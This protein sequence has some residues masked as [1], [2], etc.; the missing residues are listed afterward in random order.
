MESD[1]PAT[2]RI[3][4]PALELARSIGDPDEGSE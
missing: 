4:L 3:R 1:S 2:A